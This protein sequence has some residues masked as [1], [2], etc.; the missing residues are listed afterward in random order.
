METRAND[1]IPRREYRIADYEERSERIQR[2]VLAEKLGITSQEVNSN[3]L[4]FHFN[5]QK[6][7]L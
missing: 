7:S 1:D 3:D 4:L 2:A 6:I 5:R